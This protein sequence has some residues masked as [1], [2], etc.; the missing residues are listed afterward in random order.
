MRVCLKLR[1][2]S[3]EVPV[4]YNYLVQSLIYRRLPER[5]RKLLHDGG[6][7]EGPRRF[8]LFTFSRL[9]G[10]FTRRGE[11]LVFK[12]FVYLCVSSVFSKQMKALMKNF[13][14]HPEVRIG[15]AKLTVDSMRVV[16]FPNLE[17]REFYTLSP[18]VVTKK[19]EVTKY[20]LPHQEE[21][22]LWLELNVKRKVKVV[23][24][25]EIKSPVRVRFLKWRRTVTMYKGN[26]VVGAMGRFKFN[27]PKTAIMI[28]YLAGLGT[29]NS[30]GFGMFEFQGISVRDLLG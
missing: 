7:K 23:T 1:V 19:T 12:D 26:V 6:V 30:Q 25:R 21:Y 24:G 11:D 4:H 20:L 17:N 9:Y 16:K 27:A 8:K 18:V 3:G 14:E 13:G 22:S 5:T 28:G 2:L 29:K 10:D 15:K